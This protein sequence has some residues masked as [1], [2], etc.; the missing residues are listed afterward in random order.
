MLLMLKLNRL[1]GI[2]ESLY[3]SSALE[4]LRVLVLPFKILSFVSMHK[5]NNCC[6]YSYTEVSW[7]FLTNLIVSNS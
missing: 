5:S 1:Y 6:P 3:M 4:G 7:L 2:H